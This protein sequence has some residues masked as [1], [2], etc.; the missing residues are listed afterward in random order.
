MYRSAIEPRGR[1]PVPNTYRWWNKSVSTDNGIGWPG[2]E[3]HWFGIR[4]DLAPWIWIEVKSSK[5]MRIGNTVFTAMKKF[6]LAFIT[7]SLTVYHYRPKVRDASFRI[8]IRKA[9]FIKKSIA[10]IRLQ[11]RILCGGFSAVFRIRHILV[12]ILGSVHQTNGS[13]CKFGSARKFSKL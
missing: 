4:I 3:S 12:R 13:G 8:R 10:C 9:A 11:R 6:I 1:V 5:T 2:S 7:V